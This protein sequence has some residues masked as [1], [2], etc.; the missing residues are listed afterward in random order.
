MSTKKKKVQGKVEYQGHVG[1]AI[2][3]GP[4][5]LIPMD[6]QEEVNQPIEFTTRLCSNGISA[7]T[8]FT[9]NDFKYIELVCKNYEFEDVDLMY[10][11]NDPRKRSEGGLFIGKWNNGIV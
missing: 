1:E 2:M 5:L 6:S 7:P 3:G 11:Y 9:P 10:A 4:T 8:P